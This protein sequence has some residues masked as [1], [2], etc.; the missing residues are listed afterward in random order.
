MSRER[1]LRGACS[2]GRNTY[3]IDV[4]QE[5]DEVAQIIFD[6]SSEHRKSREIIHH[7]QVGINLRLLH[8]VPFTYARASV[9]I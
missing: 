2:C 3:T 6:N 4:P 5:N 9:F 8:A 1:P 7:E